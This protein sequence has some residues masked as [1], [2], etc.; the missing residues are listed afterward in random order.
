ME[1]GSSLKIDPLWCGIQVRIKIK[2]CMTMGVSVRSSIDVS[3]H[4]VLVISCRSQ[5][6]SVRDVKRSH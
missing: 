1:L 3:P 2:F 4:V 6:D 5:Q